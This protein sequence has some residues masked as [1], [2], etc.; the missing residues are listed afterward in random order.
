LECPVRVAILPSSD[1]AHLAWTYGRSKR[2]RVRYGRL[3]STVSRSHEPTSTS[4]PA[5]RRVSSPF[6][7]TPG[8]GSGIAATTRFTPARRI[9]SVH[10][11]V[12]PW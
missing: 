4:M 11:G 2:N 12:L 7:A 9:A 3:I 6:P 10:G 1:I 8:N 5:N